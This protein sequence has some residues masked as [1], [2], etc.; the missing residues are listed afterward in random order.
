MRLFIGFENPMN[1]RNKRPQLRLF[2]SLLPP[3]AWRLRMLQRLANR[4]KIKPIL[5]GRL[6]DAELARRNGKP[7]MRQIQLLLIPRKIGLRALHFYENL[8][9]VNRDDGDL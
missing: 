6:A 2:V 1:D 4:P 3:I 8:E 9:I 5:L 7:P